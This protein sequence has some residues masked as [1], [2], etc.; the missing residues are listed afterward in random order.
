MNNNLSQYLQDST[1]YKEK[2]IDNILDAFYELVSN[3]LKEGKEVK[4]DNLGKFSAKDMPPRK[5]TNPRTGKPLMIQ[6]KRRASFKFNKKF[7]EQ[8]QPSLVNKNQ[9]QVKSKNEKQMVT[10]NCSLVT[11]KV[12]P[13]PLP[14]ITETIWFVNIDQSTKKIS[15]SELIKNGVTK[16]TLLWNESLDDWKFAKDIPQLAYLFS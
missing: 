8:I 9:L 15:E 5:G 2:I 7:I 3:S 14:K 10:G 12:T 16:N 4:I 13:P 11:D 6:A 1:G